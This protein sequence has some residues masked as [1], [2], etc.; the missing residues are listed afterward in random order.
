MK[1]L[2]NGLQ[3]PA[4]I[5]SLAMAIPIVTWIRVS[6]GWNAWSWEVLGLSASLYWL[7]RITAG[8]EVITR[9]SR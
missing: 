2:W 7:I 3:W 9:G 6:A 8:I 4:F 5:V 1:T